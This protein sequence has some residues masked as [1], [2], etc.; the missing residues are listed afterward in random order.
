MVQIGMLSDEW[1]VRYTPLEKLL[2]K[3]LRYFHEKDGITNIRIDNEKTKTIYPS[4][5]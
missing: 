4:G 1:L 3:T 5:V 2:H